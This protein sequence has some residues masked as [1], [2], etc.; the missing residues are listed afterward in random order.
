MAGERVVTLK[1]RPEP[2][3]NG[4]YVYR[5]EGVRASIYVNKRIFTRATMPKTITLSCVEGDVFRF[6][7]NLDPEATRKQIAKLENQV[8][9]QDNLS[10][11][12]KNKS[13][14]LRV[15]AGRLIASLK[16][17]EL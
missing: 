14:A 11:V 7:H 10:D 4:D 3:K 5:R 13:Q 16:G 2:T 1:L 9:Q 15:K 8:S 12:A 17:I 6:P